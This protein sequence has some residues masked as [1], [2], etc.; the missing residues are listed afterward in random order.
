MKKESLGTE[1]REDIAYMQEAIA[2]AKCAAER[3]EIPVGAVVV[4]NGRVIGRG[5]NSRE[6]DRNAL[7]HAEIAAINEACEALSGWRLPGCK[8]YVT[9]EPCPMCAG[10][11]VNARIPEVICATKDA[12]AGA[13]GSVINLNSYPFNHKP[14]VTWGVGEG[15]ASR[16]VSDFFAELRRK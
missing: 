15:E 9:M 2:E 10:A 1:E 13:F 4:H 16:L 14:R 3:G 8:L 11:I 6:S 7:A 5:R 12:K